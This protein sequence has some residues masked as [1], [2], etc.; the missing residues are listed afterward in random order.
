M[1]SCAEVLGLV[2]VILLSLAGCSTPVAGLRPLYP[3]VD[4]SWPWVDSLQ[5]TLRWEAFPRPADLEGDRGEWLSRIRNVTYDL[6]IWRL[7][8]EEYPFEW[9]PFKWYPGEL[10]YS[11]SGLPAPTHRIELGLGRD[12]RYLWSVRARFDLDGQQRVTEWGGLL[13]SNG[14]DHDPRTAHIPALNYYR[15]LTPLYEP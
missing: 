6:R 8:S 2:A 4:R 15:I 5:P 7:K 11:K 14:R 3:N 9:Y 1:T 13:I 12:T 10:I